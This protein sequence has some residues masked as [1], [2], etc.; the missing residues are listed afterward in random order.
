MKPEYLKDRGDCIEI[1]APAAGA[2]GA[3]VTLM[4]LREKYGIDPAVSEPC[5][6]NQDWYVKEDFARTPLPAE[7]H[8]IRKEVIPATRGKRPDEV[9]ALLGAGESLPL[10]VTLTTP[11]RPVTATGVS[12]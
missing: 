8:T 11:T 2:D 5:F 1:F 12:R 3:P 6:Y 10:A 7:W 4:S 9:D